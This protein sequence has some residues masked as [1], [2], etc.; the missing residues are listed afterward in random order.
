MNL[1]EAARLTG[2]T[3]KEVDILAKA[4]WI[5]YHGRLG[6]IMVDVS[7]LYQMRMKWIQRKSKANYYS[8]TLIIKY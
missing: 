8:D 2:F 1:E 7:K 5:K 6:V 3:Y 4:G